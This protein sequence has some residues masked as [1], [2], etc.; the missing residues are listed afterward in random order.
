MPMPMELLSPPLV[1]KD[2]KERP[3]SASLTAKVPKP[4]PPDEAPKPEKLFSIREL[5]GQVQ[6][7]RHQKVAV[8]EWIEE[9]E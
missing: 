8:D 7:R 5:F 3:A 4:P 1:A 9:I 6:D 2:P